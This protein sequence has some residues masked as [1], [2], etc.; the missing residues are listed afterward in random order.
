M[1]VDENIDTDNPNT[2]QRTVRFTVND[3][4]GGTSGSSDALI[5][6]QAVNDIP[7]VSNLNGDSIN[8]NEGD[9]AVSIDQ[10]TNS[11]LTDVDSAD[12]DGGNLTATIT[13]GV[14]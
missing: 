3:G 9:G 4:D 14:L 6:I 5:N 2:A 12:F 7:S 1:F 11:T 10:G 8:Y 13:A